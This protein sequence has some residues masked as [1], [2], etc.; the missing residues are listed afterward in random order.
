MIK[1]ILILVFLLSLSLF[2]LPGGKGLGGKTISVRG[3]GG[4]VPYAKM[5][6][7]GRDYTFYYTV[8]IAPSL[9]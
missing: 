1:N 3:S 2:A 7:S 8:S 6:I 5:T 4:Y 9:F